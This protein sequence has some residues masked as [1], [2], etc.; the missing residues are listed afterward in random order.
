MLDELTHGRRVST[1]LLQREEVKSSTSSLYEEKSKTVALFFI[2]A[3]TIYVNTK[4][5]LLAA[6]PF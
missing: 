6:N 5:Y 4:G 3:S 1:F 2:R